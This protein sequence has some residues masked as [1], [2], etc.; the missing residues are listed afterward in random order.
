MLQRFESASRIYKWR[1]GPSHQPKI[2]AATAHIPDVIYQVSF[3]F[4]QEDK[5]AMMEAAY[6][7]ATAPKPKAKKGKKGKKGGK[8]RPA[9]SSSKK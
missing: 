9:T 2:L 7:A 3:L 8:S 1:C 5:K 4:Q 6:L